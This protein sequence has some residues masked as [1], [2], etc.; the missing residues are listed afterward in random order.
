MTMLAC[1]NWAVV[2]LTVIQISRYV[3]NYDRLNVDVKQRRVKNGYMYFRLGV[4][5]LGISLYAASACV[6]RGVTL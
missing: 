6:S 5:C 2:D 4:C 1:T 3:C